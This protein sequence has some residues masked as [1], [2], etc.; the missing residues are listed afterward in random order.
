MNWEKCK[1]FGVIEINPTNGTVRLYYDQWNFCLA[2]KP[3]YLHVQTASWQGNNLLLRGH[4]NYGE[5]MTYVMSDF[6]NGR[7]II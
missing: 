4:N 5:A 7:Q 3:L 1:N 6:Y 2:E